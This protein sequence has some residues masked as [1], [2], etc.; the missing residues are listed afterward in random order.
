MQLT[1]LITI[2]G[3]QYFDYYWYW[4]VYK[5]KQLIKEAEK[6][7]NGITINEEIAF[8]TFEGTD[9][10]LQFKY[11]NVIGGLLITIFYLSL[12][13]IILLIVISTFLITYWVEK[14]LLLRRHKVPC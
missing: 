4:K 12:I 3:L 8:K 6:N 11:L 14:Y 2:P 10:N 9:F 7:E 5:Q 13:P 1:Y